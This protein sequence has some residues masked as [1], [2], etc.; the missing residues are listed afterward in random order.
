M[1]GRLPG[2]RSRPRSGCQRGRL[3]THTA[4]RRRGNVGFRL[5]GM[6]EDRIF[7]FKRNDF[8]SNG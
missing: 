8:S 6:R 4:G 3:D 2:F 7:E 5:E 1:D